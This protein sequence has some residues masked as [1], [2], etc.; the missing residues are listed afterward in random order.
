[1]GKYHLLLWPFS[2]A[3]C[4]I[5]WRVGD[6]GDGDGGMGVGGWEYHIYHLEIWISMGFERVIPMNGWG[7]M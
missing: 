5:S 2:R 6:G 3:N 4:K 7:M 1:M